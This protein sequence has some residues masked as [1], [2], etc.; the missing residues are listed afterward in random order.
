[1][2]A[3]DPTIAAAWITGGVGALGIVGTVVT[4]V[5]GSRNT[6]RATEATIAASAAA[7]AATLAAAR[8]ERLW[9]KRAAAYE[10]TI[11]ELR[12][13][14]LKR[15][16]HLTQNDQ[17]WE[18]KLRDFF[19]RYEPGDLQVAARLTAYASDKVLEA[20]KAA[21]E[22]HIAAVFRVQLWRKAT[23]DNARAADSGGPSIADRHQQA[24]KAI[25]ETDAREERLI[26]VIRDEL[27]SKPEAVTLP[28]PLPAERRRFWH[29]RE[30]R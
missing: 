13:R 3:V 22:A 23:D 5:V 14:M 24:L 20:H 21:L 12:L 4:S 19:F 11:A 7:T 1:M 6:K 27:R 17:D 16:Q 9:E 26:E 28:A 18:Q 25:R 2:P 30:R 29:R 15:G 8:E 10:E